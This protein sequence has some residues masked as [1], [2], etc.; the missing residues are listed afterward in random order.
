M[1]PRQTAP[2]HQRARTRSVVCLEALEGATTEDMS[3]MREHL[4]A[5][6]QRRHKSPAVSS[7]TPPSLPGHLRDEAGPTC[8]DDEKGAKRMRSAS[9]T[10]RSHRGTDSDDY[11][12]ALGLTSVGRQETV[13]FGDGKIRKELLTTQMN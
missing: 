4:T 1:G 9:T 7:L 3:D 6:R 8:S 13:R 11:D 12:R 2:T 5:G 10:P